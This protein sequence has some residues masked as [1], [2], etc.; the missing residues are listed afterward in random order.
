VRGRTRLPR[1]CRT[2]V[3]TGAPQPRRTRTARKATP[4][5]HRNAD[6]GAKRPV[7]S[8]GARRRHSS[9]DAIFLIL[10]AFALRAISETHQFGAQ[11]H[12]IGKYPRALQMEI[13]LRARVKVS[14]NGR[15][16][17]Q[18]TTLASVKQQVDPIL[19]GTSSHSR[20]LPRHGSTTAKRAIRA[21]SGPAVSR[22]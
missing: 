1:G 5:R 8:S 19:L 7:S 10:V 15:W 18:D 12:S 3:G 16:L 9:T 13:Q 2:A 14:R 6:R 21:A 20:Q 17:I 11:Y 22:L 4:A